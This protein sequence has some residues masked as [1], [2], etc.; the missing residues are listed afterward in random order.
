MQ[1]FGT[2]HTHSFRERFLKNK[3]GVFG[4]CII[5][6]TSIIAVLA[7]KIAPD[8]TPNA[9]RQTIE[10]QAKNPGYQQQF[11]VVPKKSTEMKSA[12][13][14]FFFGTPAV[15]DYIPINSYRISGN[16]LMVDYHVDDD[17][18]IIKSFNINSITNNR[19]NSIH[20]HIITRHF[21]L[22]TDGMG[23]DLMSRMII[24]SRVS[25]SVGLIAVLIA[26][27]I[28]IT[29]GAVA[30]YFGGS[31]DSVISIIINIFWSMPS[32]LMVFAFTI[33]MGKGFWQIFLAIGV[34][35]W[36]GLARL[37]RAEVMRCRSLEYVAAAKTMGLGSARI[38]FRHIL[39][40]ISGSII[41]MATGIFASAIMI[42]AGLSFLGL[43]VQP[44]QPSWGG[45]IKENYTFLITHKPMLAIA[46]GLAIMLLVLSFNLLG[47][48]L[49]DAL[50]VRSN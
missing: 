9:D 25:L 46:P 27:F 47:N 21:Y 50:D 26:L 24:G 23:R 29:L 43:G 3:P 32:L 5:I 49:R 8:N 44:P 4:L 7:Y 14:R 2:T 34:T 40:N 36:V 41:V 17:T 33:A 19:P 13:G 38:I 20:E 15:D 12:F 39:P 37:V 30:G 18:S 31:A 45:I 35:S 48:G 16:Q 10:I 6:I 42:E 1:D 11:L 22:G 28:G